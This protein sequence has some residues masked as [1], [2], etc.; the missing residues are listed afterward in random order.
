MFFYCTIL[1][2]AF[3]RT[4]TVPVRLW[5]MGGELAT[6]LKDNGKGLNENGGTLWFGLWI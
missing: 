5:L 6:A 2:K 1:R 3:K 4:K